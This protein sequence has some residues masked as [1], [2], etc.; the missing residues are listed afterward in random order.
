MQR[1]GL[2]CPRV[3]TLKKHVLVMSFIGNNSVPAPQLRDAKLGPADIQDAYDQLLKVSIL[4][5]LI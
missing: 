5:M 4:Q 2:P 3:V 1:H